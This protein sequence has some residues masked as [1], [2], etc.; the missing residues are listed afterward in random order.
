[1]V[2]GSW[3]MVHGSWFM[4][5][6]SSEYTTGLIES[7]SRELLSVVQ[8]SKKRPFL[9]SSSGRGKD[10]SSHHSLRWV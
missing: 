10:R 7:V 5:H 3:F 9:K 6:G 8:G 2:H 4:V 1:M